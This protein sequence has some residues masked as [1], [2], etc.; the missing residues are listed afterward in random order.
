[1]NIDC[2]TVSHQTGFKELEATRPIETTVTKSGE[3]CL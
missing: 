3:N 1:M 2:V